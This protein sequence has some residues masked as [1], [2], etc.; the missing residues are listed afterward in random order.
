MPVAPQQFAHGRVWPYSGEQFILFGSDHRRLPLLRNHG[1]SSTSRRT[2]RR[3]FMTTW[4]F[5]GSGRDATI[6]NVPLLY[7]MLVPD[8][9]PTPRRWPQ[10]RASL[11]S[12]ARCAVPVERKFVVGAR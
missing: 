5:S 9:L 11:A 10:P 2:L 4:A 12:R 1:K 7:A 6:S 3:S 8:V